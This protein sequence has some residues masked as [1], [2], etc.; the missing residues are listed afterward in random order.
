MR[1]QVRVRATDA[2]SPALVATLTVHVNVRRNFHAPR[3][4]QRT[5]RVTVDAESATIGTEVSNV[6]TAVD[7]DRQVC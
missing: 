4:V 2:G 6:V 3:W 5:A 1:L 7:A